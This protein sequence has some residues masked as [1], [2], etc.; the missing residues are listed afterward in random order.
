MDLHAVIHANRQ[1]PP[2]Q[3]LQRQGNGKV[4]KCT[5]CTIVCI[6]PPSS[7]KSFPFPPTQE[8]EAQTYMHVNPAGTFSLLSVYTIT[9]PQ[10]SWEVGRRE[11]T[12]SCNLLRFARQN[13][14]PQ[15]RD[16]QLGG[17]PFF[18]RRNRRVSLRR[19]REQ[20]GKN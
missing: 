13:C 5:P 3:R 9:G 7:E 4:D 6:L 8:S 10:R 20:Q 2:R 17:K 12:T 14:W 11:G 18:C 19:A 16:A 1:P 15:G